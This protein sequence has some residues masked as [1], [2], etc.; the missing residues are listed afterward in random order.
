MCVAAVDRNYKKSSIS[1]Y[2]GKI[3]FLGPG[4]EVVSTWNTDDNALAK[5]TGTSIVSTK[6]ENSE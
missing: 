1:N 2:G 6:I 3:T 4:E 5:D